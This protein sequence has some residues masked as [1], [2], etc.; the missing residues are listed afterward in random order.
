MPMIDPERVL[1][2]AA[3]ADDEVLGCGG[4]IAK[5]AKA[6]STVNIAFLADG[7]SSRPDAHVGTSQHA[8]RRTA[9]HHACRLLGA[10]P[11][12]FFDFPDNQLDTVS[13]LSLVKVIESLITEHRPT[14]ILSHHGGDTN[15]DHR[16]T[17]EAI[18]AACRPQPG[19][20]VRTV[21]AFE[22]ASSTEWQFPNA[23]SHFS[24]NWYEDITDHLAVKLEALRAYADELRP[25][26]HPRCCE[27]I[28]H[29]AKWR[30]AVIGTE[31]AEAFL[32]GRHIQ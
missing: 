21:L 12:S 17:H 8:A 20:P 1:V 19:H 24:P 7:V 3:H 6:G 2:V 28:F 9:A 23:A 16:R 14:L 22:V 10:R 32:L 5:M 15:I 4:T 27:S 26:P 30:G 18:V 13:L 31:A 25:P 29:L 11:P